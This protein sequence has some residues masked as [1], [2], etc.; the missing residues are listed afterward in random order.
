M[1]AKTRKNIEAI[2]IVCRADTPRATQI[3]RELAQWLQG[4]EIKVYSPEGSQFSKG[5]KKLSGG[6][7]LDK[8]DLII[9]LGGDGTYLHAVRMLD[10]RQTPILGIN[11][12]S[13]GFLTENR[14]EEM[15]KVVDLTLKNKMD[16][17]PRA[18]LGIQVRRKGKIRYKASAL[19]DVAI[20]RGPSPQLINLSVSCGKELVTETK[21]DG[22]IIASPT[23][24]TAYN[25]AAGGPILHPTV[26]AI[27]VTPICPHS[28]TNR[29][30][31]FPDHE[32]LCFRV[33][34]KGRKAIMS[35]DGQSG[36]ELTS[37]DEVLIKRCSKDHMVVRKPG[38]NY[39]TLLR[40]KL[41]FGERA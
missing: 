17:R 25:L 14:I 20:E 3:G 10:G 39:F 35:V 11:L 2:G 6:K 8:V 21:A 36:T 24:S 41:K 16:Y 32:E 18:T 22:M 26:S 30:I 28:L 12:G 23:G 27:V 31:L 5:V 9:V 37:Q 38:H 1:A 4:K 29:P 13:L 40:E 19:N 34:G 33:I 15:Y 7:T